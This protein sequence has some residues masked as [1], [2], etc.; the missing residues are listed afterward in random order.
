MIF[1]NLKEILTYKN[2]IPYF[3]EINEILKKDLLSYTP[4]HY[5]INERLSF[6][7]AEYQTVTDKQFE[8]HRK[9][10]DLQIILQ[11]SER[12]ELGS[13]LMQFDNYDED[14]DCSVADGIAI[15]FI[16]ASIKDCI[17]FYPNEPHKP[18]LTNLKQSDVKKI[19]FKIKEE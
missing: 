5:P 8:C 14:E 16:F 17:I 3:S 12:L 2:V 13:N 10:I 18:G 15:S 11:G 4:G 7:I 1:T 9:T 19:I 6:N